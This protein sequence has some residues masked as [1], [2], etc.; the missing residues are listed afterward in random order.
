MNIKRIYRK[1]LVHGTVESALVVAIATIQDEPVVMTT[2]KRH[3]RSVY[4]HTL[5]A[6]ERLFPKLL[7]Y[8]KDDDVSVTVIRFR[9]D[10]SL[11]M[12]KPCH[13]C[14]W[15]LRNAGVVHVY[16]SDMA[17]EIRKLF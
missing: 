5:H 3:S 14:D 15:L 6:E 11:A 2:N 1:A 8:V 16:Y 17:G 7:Y 4:S 10:G 9:K 13:G 12:A